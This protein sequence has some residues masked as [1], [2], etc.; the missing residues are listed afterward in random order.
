MGSCRHVKQWQQYYTNV[1]LSDVQFF[2]EKYC[3]ET[4]IVHVDME[5]L[6]LKSQQE[7]LSK[8]QNSWFTL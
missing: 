4:I 5:S 6:L 2:I 3:S 7:Y 1:V 8:L